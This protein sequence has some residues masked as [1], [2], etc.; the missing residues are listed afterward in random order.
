MNIKLFFIS[1]S[2]TCVFIILTVINLPKEEKLP[3]VE[4][5]TAPTVKPTVVSFKSKM[6]EIIRSY[7]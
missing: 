7:L 5:Q 4:I 2:I 6:R 3:V 1:L